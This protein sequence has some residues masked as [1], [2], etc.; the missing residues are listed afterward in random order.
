MSLIPE[1]IAARLKTCTNFP[2]PPPVAMRVIELAQNPEIDL[3]T[4]ADAVSGDPAIAAKVM[5]IANSALYARRRQSSN[6]RQA[7]IVL[8]LNATLT[9]AL[10]FTLVATLRKSPPK[11]FDFDAYWRRAIVAAT[12][13]KLLANE[14][15]RRDAEEIFLGCLLQDIGMLAI[16]KIAPDVYESISPF[17]LDHA[18]VAQHE[19]THIET[20]HRAIGAWLLDDWNMPANLVRAVSHSHDLTA[21]GV[22]PEYKGFIR[23]VAMSGELSDLWCGNPDEVSIRRA[24]QEA[25]HHLGIVPNRLA[26]MFEVIREQLPVAESIFEMDLFD[27]DYLQD[28]TDTAREI[29]MIRNL[30]TL[31]ENRDLEEQKSQL[32]SANN[33]LQQEA[34][35]DG[36]TG[37]FNRRYFDEAVDK[38]YATAVKHDWPLSVIFVDIDRFKQINDTHGHQSGDKILREVAGLLRGNVRD[39]DI[40]ARYGGDEFVLLLPG[41]AREGA[42][43]IAERMIADVRN[44]SVD[45]AD[46]ERVAITLS[47][48]VA[49]FDAASKFD[50]SAE[51]LSAADEALYHSK[52]NGRDQLT[53]YDAIQAA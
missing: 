24:G 10:S 45:G 51:L 27:A 41:L 53:R 29:L 4:V 1:Q 22:D 39:S 35:S 13:G 17:Q 40:V 23:A 30:H 34:S 42:G 19:K 52:R 6:L 8:G 11:G 50:N 31:T 3:G 48:G 18:R 44:K 28:I 33:V 9:L 21:A 49:T 38:E 26:E 36:L 20:D 47:L 25:H 12:W 46:G 43:K 16:D 7:L 32:E 14:L 5:R 37:V 15:G 2:S